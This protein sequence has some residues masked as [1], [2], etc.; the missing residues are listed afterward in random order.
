VRCRFS[1]LHTLLDSF[2]LLPHTLAVLKMWFAADRAF[3]Y[4]LVA[5]LRF[6]LNE[7]SCSFSD[8]VVH[9]KNLVAKMKWCFVQKHA[10]PYYCLAM[11]CGERKVLIL[12]GSSHK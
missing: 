12:L 2:R 7:E 4:L 8:N 9:Q 10:F 3:I 1:L 5:P 6:G 11:K